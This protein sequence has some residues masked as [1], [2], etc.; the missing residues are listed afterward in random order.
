M[1]SYMSN[2]YKVGD[3]VKWKT[4]KGFTAGEVVEIV[5]LQ[6]DAEQYHVNASKNMPKYKVKSAKTGKKAVHKAEALLKI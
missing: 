1:G 2:S 5:T 3:Q 6:S 4:S